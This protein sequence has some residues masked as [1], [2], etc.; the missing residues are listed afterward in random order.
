MTG[1][2]ALLIAVDSFLDPGFQGLQSPEI[3]AKELRA[4]LEDPSL[5]NFNVQTLHNCVCGEAREKLEE[6][7]GERTHDDLTLLYF[8]G[9]GYRDDSGSLH[10]IV[11]DTRR[12]YLHATSLSAEYVNARADA[13]FAGRK[14]FIIDSCYSGAFLRRHG[15]SVD[16]APTLV[17]TDLVP[18]DRGSGHVY[19]TASRE[20]EVSFEGDVAIGSPSTSS[21]T[22][23]LIEG[24]KSGDADQNADGII[25]V[26]EIFNYI[27]TKIKNTEKGKRQTPQKFAVR[28]E[29]PIEIS[30]SP[31]TQNVFPPKILELLQEDDKFHNFYAVDRLEQ[32]LLDSD[33]RKVQA[34]R[35]ML[36]EV[37]R[38]HKFPSVRAYALEALNAGSRVPHVNVGPIATSLLSRSPTPQR[39]FTEVP[40]DAERPPLDDLAPASALSLTRAATAVSVETVVSEKVLSNKAEPSK[41]AGSPVTAQDTGPQL[42]TQSHFDDE[43][44][45]ARKAQMQVERMAAEQRLK[46]KMSAIAASAPEP[47]N[48]PFPGANARARA[49]S[50]SPT[51]SPSDRTVWLLL[52]VFSIL[53]LTVLIWLARR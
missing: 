51:P 33:S 18:T 37:W 12:K 36:E 48:A 42:P 25:D 45:K 38:T 44:R 17:Q 43:A 19:L 8:S 47:S 3:D 50:T 26:D 10:F 2:Y 35:N 32:L 52:L 53:L 13:S 1:R 30:K 7:F 23:H 5:G 22:K 34:A 46:E 39:Q 41:L 29:G 21:F 11:H 4:V 24:I 16:Q 9:H 49:P 14:V 28:T 27:R 20:F 6:F 31:K 15:K 40:A